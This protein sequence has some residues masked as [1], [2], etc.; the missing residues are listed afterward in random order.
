MQTV[1]TI[2]TVWMKTSHTT[3]TA[4]SNKWIAV[5]TKCMCMHS[6]HHP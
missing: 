1:E 5:L 3:I 2:T 6:H 4:I